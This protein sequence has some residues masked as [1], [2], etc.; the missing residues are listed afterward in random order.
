MR[1]ALAALLVLLACG[2]KDRDSAPP[3]PP[4]PAIAHDAATAAPASANEA[5]YESLLDS[6]PSPCGAAHSLRK[7]LQPAS[8][9][10][11]G[12]FAA[13]Y[14]QRLV[15][16]GGEADQIRILYEDKY[17]YR[18]QHT[19][20][21]G[22]TPFVGGRDA[23]VVLVEF[24]DYACPFCRRLS[25]GLE[26]LVESYQGRVALYYKMAP[27]V[28]LHPRSHEAARAALAAHDQ[29]A[30]A[31]MHDLLFRDPPQHQPDQLRAAAEA[32]GLDMERF[33][34]DYAAAGARVDADLAEATAAE[35]A[36]TPTIFIN[37]VMYSDAISEAFL[38]MWIDEELAVISGSASP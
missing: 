33:D 11:R 32:A 15:G 30:H 17:V 6:L 9:C 27:I 35:V 18:K 7:S 1:A 37:G 19:F 28:K 24:L 29:G 10:A 26:K 20:T 36:K 23:A 34:R 16:N 25:P 13:R 4:P 2:T 12:S 21:L 38:R 3:P 14:L 31:A 8:A 22:S 5:L